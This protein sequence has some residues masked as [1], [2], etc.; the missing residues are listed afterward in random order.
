MK[1]NTEKKSFNYAFQLGKK[2]VFEV[3][4]YILRNNKNKYFSTSAAL[5]NHIRSDFNTCG[6]AQEELT[7][8][9]HT[10]RKFY[11]K[12]DPLHLKDLTND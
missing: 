3:S 4:Y 5:F 9:Y 6:Q 2:I 12:F 11:N 1:A 7:K 8:L 10:A